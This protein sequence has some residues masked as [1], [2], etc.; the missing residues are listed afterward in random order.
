MNEEKSI[1]INITGESPV[2]LNFYNV[3]AEDA[4]DVVYAVDE[5]GNIVNASENI[6]RSARSTQKPRR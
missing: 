5:N 1:V 2:T 4:Q 6:D 3:I